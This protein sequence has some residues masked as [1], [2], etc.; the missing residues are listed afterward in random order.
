[1]ADGTITFVTDLD[2]KQ[3]ERALSKTK[4]EIADLTLKIFDTKTKKSLLLEQ[5]EKLN[6]EL[7]NARIKQ[8]ELNSRKFAPVSDSQREELIAQA[9]LIEKITKNIEDTQ[10]AIEQCDRKI[11]TFE[12]NIAV[13]EKRGGALEQAIAK[14]NTE[15]NDATD[16]VENVAQSTEQASASAEEAAKSTENMGESMEG[17]EKS[18]SSFSSA[19]TIVKLT[20]KAI[21]TTIKAV[22]STTY[23]VVSS[24]VKGFSTATKAIVKTIGRLN[25][26]KKISEKIGP[27]FSRIGNLIQRAFVFSTITSGLRYLK[28][29]LTTYLKANTE[30][31]QALGNVKG[32]LLTAFQ[33]IY[34][35]VV[36]AL[37]TLLNI[38][39]KIISAI[40]SFTASLFGSTAKAAQSNA[41]SLYDQAKATEAAGSAA[42][43][44]KK[45]L[46]AFDEI[47]QLTDN[48]ESGGGASDT[49]VPSLDLDMEE[50]QY[51]TWGEA[52]DAFLDKVINSLPKLDAA[53]QVAAEKINEFS[54][55][56]LEMFTFPGVAEKV[57]LVGMELANSL[58]RF[59]NNV[60]WN[61]LGQAIG[62]GI[63]L[64]LTF[65]VSFLY[66]FDWQNFGSKIAEFLNG[67]ISQIDWTQMGQLLWSGFK[68]AI[69]T[70]AGMILGMDMSLVGNAITEFATGFFNS[71]A[72]TLENI[73]WNGIGN[74][75]KTLIVNIDWA[76]IADAAFRALG[77][78]FGAAAGFLW[79]LIKDAWDN[80][81]QWWHDN[82]FEDGKFTLQGL[83]DGIVEVVNN[84][85]TWIK[86]HIF[87]PFIDGFKK[88]FGIN[89]PSKVMK[90]QGGYIMSGLL[91][92]ITEGW[93]KL[94]E[95]F[96]STI[97]PK[98][99]LQYWKD[100]FKNIAEGFSAKIKDGINVGIDLFNKFIDWINSKM[101][102]SWGSFS[103]FGKEIIPAGSL[104]LLTL[105]HIPRLAQGA[106]IPPN[107]EFM[108]VL[109]DQTSGNNIE[110]PENLIRQ[111]VREE[112]QTSASN[113]LLREILSAIR[114]G[115]VMMVDS[116][117]F[118]KVAQRSLSNAS[119][120][121]GTPLTVR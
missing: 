97:K 93:T 91:N 17:A 25:V 95:W 46:A 109:G 7:D 22:V 94:K 74:Q 87:Q 19:M 112:T 29:T 104:T 33:P 116:V 96:N 47:N 6:S 81:V 16:G 73:D 58:N 79:G 64:A 70:L 32:A 52:F 62:A 40:A 54:A 48:K 102:L 37:T 67:A 1:M 106:V 65:A 24:I 20:A 121:S 45:Q 38:L 107:R 85:G 75:F 118:A 44:A 66:T 88:A 78:A 71:A 80:V 89:S 39:T 53:L 83:L 76:S 9:E 57:A 103:L 111:I 49:S 15:T 77:A 36:P 69:E 86:E 110:A 27:V 59:V 101:T 4:K 42:D 14:V 105:P 3:L 68:I 31:M 90:E 5:V 26:F 12:T 21:V 35:A 8:D 115:K 41:K 63:N 43:K 117:Q 108:A 98:L 99:T 72:E 92:G 28:N 113:D 119:R 60:N 30:F 23:K 61:Q 120:A 2:N 51:K 50:K 11:E 13:A 18:A 84:I 82:A 55:K 100:K 56:L 10:K 34:S 114:E